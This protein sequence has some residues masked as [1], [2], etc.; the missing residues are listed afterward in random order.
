MTKS[1]KEILAE[2]ANSQKANTL[3][4]ERTEDN[5]A[6]ISLAAEAV[7]AF[8][9]RSPGEE[10]DVAT[11]F[12]DLMADLFHLG[13]CLHV[14]GFYADFQLWRQSV[15]LTA[16]GHF[17]AE[18]TEFSEELTSHP[19]AAFALLSFLH[20]RKQPDHHFSVS[21]RLLATELVMMNTRLE[22]LPKA[23]ALAAVIAEIYK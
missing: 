23:N 5:L 21:A 7:L 13:H 10:R 14:S 20:S 15:L 2:L 16:M 6:H 22:S 12:A 3:Q 1:L 4:D 19:H 18:T 9:E 17:D 11:I 8:L